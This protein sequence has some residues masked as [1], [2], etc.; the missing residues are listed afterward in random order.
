MPDN[1]VL[2]IVARQFAQAK[3]MTK[4][5]CQKLLPGYRSLQRHVFSPSIKKIKLCHSFRKNV[6]KTKTRK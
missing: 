4:S 6:S 2:Y 1:L 3:F 5:R